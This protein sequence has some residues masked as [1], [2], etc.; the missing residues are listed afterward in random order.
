MSPTEHE[1]EC[2][3]YYGG[4]NRAGC[5]CAP[6]R[7]AYHRGAESVQEPERLAITERVNRLAAANL[8]GDLHVLLDE[9]LGAINDL[10]DVD[11]EVPASPSQQGAGDAALDAWLATHAE[12][13]D[14]NPEL[15]VLGDHWEGYVV[16]REDLEPLFAPTVQQGAGAVAA[17]I[18]AIDEQH[19]VE[20]EQENGPGAT[21]YWCQRCQTYGYDPLERCFT[22][23][24]TKP[25]R[26]APPVPGPATQAIA[27]KVD[28][29]ALAYLRRIHG[30]IPDEWVDEWQATDR[31]VHLMRNSLIDFAA[32]LLSVAPTTTPEG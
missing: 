1:P 11:Y 13:I 7:S 12:S 27:A 16:K 30:T 23:E 6:L 19:P 31:Y 9:V 17:L 32:A 8:S 20:I 24:L 25:F 26:S 5:I 15:Q 28:E 10:P 4:N 14:T 18:A 22:V 2:V 21:E 3:I 29:W